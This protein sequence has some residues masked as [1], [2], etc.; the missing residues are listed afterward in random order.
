MGQ[1][2][3]PNPGSGRRGARSGVL[4]RP[5]KKGLPRL[6]HQLRRRWRS[7]L[8][9]SPLWIVLFVLASTWCLLPRRVFFVPPVEV[10]SIAARTYIADEDLSVTNDSATQALQEQARNEVLPVY[11]F[12][13]AIE[14]DARRQ[15]A[16][17]FEA[18]R[19]ALAAPEDEAQEQAEGARDQPEPQA[20]TE[21]LAAVGEE[22]VEDPGADLLARLAEQSTFKITRTQVEL[23]IDK[24]FSTEIED[25][26]AAVL[27]RVFRQGVVSDKELVLEH[28]V[29]GITVQE[30]PSGVRDTQLDLYGYLD[31]P[32]QVVQVV[33]L[34]LLNWAGVRKRQRTDFAELVLANVSP[35]L[36]FNSSA[37]LEL[38]QEAANT[39]GTVAHSIRQGEVIVRKGAKVDE[40]TAR[41]IDQMAGQRDLNR[42]LLTGLGTFFLLVA[43]SLL[44]W[45]M[46]GQEKRRDRSRERFCSECLILLMLHILGARFAYFVAEALGNAIQREPYNSVASYS[47]AIPLASL[48]LL[49]V[50][51]YGR[52]T[53]LVLSLVFSLL[54][55][56]IVVGEAIW[57]MMVYCLASSLAAVYALDHHQFKQRSAMTRAG[58]V[59]GLINVVAL[60]ALE[61]MGG[62]VSGGLPQ[63][64]FDLLCGFLG[65]LLAAAVASFSVPIFETLFQITTSIKLIELANPNLPILR[66]LAFEAPGTFQHSLAV[67][68]LAKSGCEAIDGDSVLVHTGALYHDIGKIFRPRYFIENQIP[69]QN[70]HDRIQASMS[71]LILINHVKEGLE[72]AYKLDL[73]Q[74]IMDA[75]EQ[76]HGSRLIK[77]FYNRAKERCDP[78]TEEVREEEFRYPGPKPQSKEMG[79]LML[80]DGV[81]AASRTLVNPGRQQIRHLIQTLIEDCLHD[82]QLDETDLTLSDLHKV[83]EAFL[84]VLTNIYHRR[85]DYPGFDFNRRSGR[86]ENRSRKR[87]GES[88]HEVPAPAIARG[89]AKTASRPAESSRAEPDLA[90]SNLAKTDVP[91]TDLAETNPA[92]TDA[93]RRAS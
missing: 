7:L 38:R 93:A 22:A 86:G 58:C 66:R 91:E 21:G 81:E 13:R 73:P 20:V 18:G 53:A 32:E 80:A 69:G 61:A 36:T 52:N 26:L 60:L 35:N 47:F 5:P 27:N 11:D 79:V 28:R 1:K 77:F 17:L 34:D 10:G 9:L 90:E 23:L 76:H 64:G 14:A 71:A 85:V 88:S 19:A 15:L 16:Q 40:I 65:G 74:P 55:G 87:A 42:L 46:C 43:A 83:E 41:A 45:L 54:V 29:R 48:A 12:D 51:L 37:T 25:R 56:H 24:E 68:N 70:P 31:Y 84:R 8:E 3:S 72:L 63:I 33:E 78:C 59:V 4:R 44:V 2:K 49:A 39:V 89:S 67:A 30:L 57:M 62:E 6:Q 75:I 92:E 50:L 82:G